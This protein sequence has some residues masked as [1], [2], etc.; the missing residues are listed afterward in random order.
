MPNWTSV[1]TFC[2]SVQP[3]F[4]LLLPVALKGKSEM[5]ERTADLQ[6]ACK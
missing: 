2:F 5:K 4:I 6:N 3:F 1:F